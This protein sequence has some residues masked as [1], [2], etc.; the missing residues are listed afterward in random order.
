MKPHG[1]TS[2]NR[3]SFPVPVTTVH[4]NDLPVVRVNLVNLK[5]KGKLFFQITT[6]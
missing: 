5:L 3:F 2:T 6:F 4:A 1:I